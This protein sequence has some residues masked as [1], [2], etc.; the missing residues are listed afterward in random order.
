V[1][2]ERARIEGLGED[3]AQQRRHRHPRRAVRPVAPPRLARA[4][5]AVPGAVLV[6]VLLL[7]RPG[8]G[9]DDVALRC[10]VRA[11]CTPQ[12]C[13]S[14]P[15]RRPRGSCIGGSGSVPCASSPS[16]PSSATSL[17][18]PPPAPTVRPPF[19]SLTREL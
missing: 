16:S 13:A 9:E 5:L 7:L 12:R 14:R 10:G 11:Q 15:K 2:R 19:L 1:P 6:L 3:E 17:P 8:G 4:L 18:P